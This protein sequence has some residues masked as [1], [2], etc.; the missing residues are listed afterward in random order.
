MAMATATAT[1]SLRR[2]LVTH[3]VFAAIVGVNVTGFAF[4]QYCSKNGIPN[5]MMTDSTMNK[6]AQDAI[7]DLLLRVNAN[8]N[9]NSKIIAWASKED[10]KF[11]AVGSMITVPAEQPVDNCLTNAILLH[12]I[13][14]VVGSRAFWSICACD[15]AVVTALTAA[16]WRFGPRFGLVGAA[17]F[18]RAS[19]IALTASVS[20]EVCRSVVSDLTLGRTNERTADACAIKHG[21]YWELMAFQHWFRRMHVRE[22]AAGA[23]LPLLKWRLALAHAFDEHPPHAERADAVKAGIQARFPDPPPIEITV[24]HT[25]LWRAV[26]PFAS[27]TSTEVLSR[28]N[29]AY[30]RD[31][32]DLNALGLPSE[33]GGLSKVTLYPDRNS[34]QVSLTVRQHA[35]NAECRDVLFTVADVSPD[36]RAHN[37]PSKLNA[38]AAKALALLDII[39]RQPDVREVCFVQFP[40]PNWCCEGDDDEDGNDAGLR[41]LR[42]HIPRL[43]ND[44]NR[45]DHVVGIVADQRALDARLGKAVNVV[46]VITTSTEYSEVDAWLATHAADLELM[47]R[48]HGT[49]YAYG[50]AVGEKTEE[51]KKGL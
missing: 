21:T 20:S 22:A 19:A 31:W 6:P 32:I 48:E 34:C 35:L 2:A 30:V 33:I 13:G 25:S 43:W 41:R 9:S 49:R 51:T 27:S 17:F 3:R 7:D 44:A 14:H 18:S 36:G 42:S 15:A 45:P 47:P 39:R 26:W 11:A 4:Q 10:G 38:S 40:K 24:C 28:A 23:I 16:L 50:Q 29:S 12:E 8:S 1:M 37:I 5:W 46:R